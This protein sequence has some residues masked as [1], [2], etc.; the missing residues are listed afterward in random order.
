MERARRDEE[1][2]IRLHHAVLRHHVR[3]FDDRQQVALDALA[4]DVRPAHLRALAGDLVD[5]VEEDDPQLLDALQRV[6]GDVLH[7]DELV[8]FLIE[9]DAA[10]LAHLDGALLLS[11]RQQLLQHVAEVLH[12]LG[13]AG[14]GEDIDGRPGRR[15]LDLELAL[16]ELTVLEQLTELVARTLESLGLD[17]LTLRLALWSNEEDIVLGGASRR[18]VLGDRALR[19]RCA[20]ND[21]LLWWQQQ[22]ENPLL[23]LFLREILDLAFAFGAHHVDGAVHEVAYHALHV[24]ADVADLGELGGLDLHERRARELCQAAGDLGLADSGGTDED[25]VVRRDLAANALRSSLPAPPIPQRDRHG[26]LG[27]RLAHDV[28]IQLGDYLPRREVGEL[29]EG[30]GGTVGGHSDLKIPDSCGE[31]AKDRER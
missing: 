4:R 18:S 28:A 27:V 29:G 17:V 26:L 23:D 8:V 5:L 1:D 3:A 22:I 14:R 12:A 19:G 24:A 20:C 7:V 6:A 11:L 30:L 2:V 21:G 13:C 10:R 9:Q 31:T 16:L 15:D 25:D